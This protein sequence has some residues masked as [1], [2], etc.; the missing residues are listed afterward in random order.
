MAESLLRHNGLEEPLTE[1]NVMGFLRRHNAMPYCSE[2]SELILVR[3]GQ[4]LT[5]VPSD[6]HL[7][8]EKARKEF[9]R[10]LQ[11]DGKERA[12][13]LRLKLKAM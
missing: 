2:E 9:Q 6:K 1:E 3:Q 4:R 10:I 7:L 12:R 8:G 13:E 11:V 5:D